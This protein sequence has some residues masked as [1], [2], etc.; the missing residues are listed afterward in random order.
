MGI[1]VFKQDKALSSLLDMG[2]CEW[3]MKKKWSPVDSENRGR[4]SQNVALNI[5]LWELS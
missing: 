4:I 2:Q 3:G 5:V 1:I